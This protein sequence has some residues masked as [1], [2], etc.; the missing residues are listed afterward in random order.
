[1]RLGGLVARWLHF[2]MTNAV[3]RRMPSFCK[4]LATAKSVDLKTLVSINR[5]PQFKLFVTMFGNMTA[6]VLDGIEWN[7]RFGARNA[8]TT[9]PDLS[10]E[11]VEACADTRFLAAAIKEKFRDLRGDLLATWCKN[12]LQPGRAWSDTPRV[13]KPD[14]G[15]VA[16]TTVSGAIAC[17]VVYTGK[18][19]GILRMPASRSPIEVTLEQ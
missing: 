1:M 15:F 6:N 4:N 9:D 13:L 19:P 12:R 18:I 5:L 2:C 3:L 10:A 11:A 16:L 8:R 17:Y 14:W 7:R